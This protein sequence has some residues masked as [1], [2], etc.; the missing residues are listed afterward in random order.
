MR[1]SPHASGAYNH[2]NA[3]GELHTL[4]PLYC[5][6]VSPRSTEFCKPLHAQPSQGSPKAMSG[7]VPAAGAAGGGDEVQLDELR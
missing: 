5:I 6:P 1:A 4:Q 7:L 3:L 2:F